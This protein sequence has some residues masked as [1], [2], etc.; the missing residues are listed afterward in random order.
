MLIL[1]FNDFLYEFLLQPLG[2][3]RQGL[4]APAIGFLLVVLGLAV[5]LIDRIVETGSSQTRS[6]DEELFQK[7]LR[8]LPWLELND[9][10][11]DLHNH[12]YWDR[13]FDLVS[14]LRVFLENEANKF[15]DRK[16]QNA[17]E[18][19]QNELISVSGF[20]ACNF[21][22][23]DGRLD[24]FLM[25]PNISVDRTGHDHPRYIRASVEVE[26]HIEKLEAAYNSYVA[27][28]RTRGF[29]PRSE[30]AE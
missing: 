25:L 19:Y 1:S 8:M 4:A 2:F 7:T 23:E 21:S 5:M 3:Q 9:F 20:A 12:Y 24:R 11:N 15:V 29:V 28:G 27:E 30:T 18:K 13:H 10:L 6:Q 14:D 26:K 17:L 16:M 22:P